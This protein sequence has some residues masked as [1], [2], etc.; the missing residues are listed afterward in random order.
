[1]ASVDEKLRRSPLSGARRVAVRIS[2]GV[3]LPLGVHDCHEGVNL[4]VFSRHAT[5][6]ALLLFDDAGQRAPS[7]RIELDPQQH[8]T[9]DIWHVRLQSWRPGQLY[10]LQ[11]DGPNRPAEGHRFD[12]QSALLDPYA[13]LVAGHQNWQAESAPRG[14]YSVIA[15]HGFDWQGDKPLR[16]PWR[17]TV[18]YETHVRGL[19]IHPSL[20]VRHRGQHLGL[21]EKIP[22]FQALGVTALELMACDQLRRDRQPGSVIFTNQCP[23]QPRRPEKMPS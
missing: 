11:A 14:V 20:G 7:E 1:M 15:D 13:S 21:V 3:P 10:A 17:E 18:I 2:P 23:I 6:M 16:R 22:Y 4:A 12:A 9:G 19:T 5:S 8:R